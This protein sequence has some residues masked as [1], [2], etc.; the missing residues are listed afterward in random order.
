[1]NRLLAL[2]I[3][4]ASIRVRAGCAGALRAIAQSRRAELE[5]LRF[6]WG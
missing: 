3:A 6:V 2:I 4:L 5:H 1:M